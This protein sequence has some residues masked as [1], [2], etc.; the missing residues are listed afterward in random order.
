MGGGEGGAVVSLCQTAEQESL[1][2]VTK[3]DETV[4]Y[5]M[6]SSTSK[7]NSHVAPKFYN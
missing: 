5:L 4:A 1:T 2:E 6:G 3:H 7:S